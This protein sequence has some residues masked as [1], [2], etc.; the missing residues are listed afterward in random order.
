MTTHELLCRLEA[1]RSRGT[2][3][4]LARCPSHKD[5]SPS[6]SIGEGPDRILLHCFALCDNRD[7]VATVGFTMADLFFD[8]PIPRG[9]R[10]IARPVRIDYI[11]LAFRHELAALDRRLRAA[12]VL[13]VATNFSV[14]GLDHAQ[15]DRLMEAI[16]SAYSD[17]ER[18]EFLETVAD[19]LRV[20]AF[21]ERTA[22]HAA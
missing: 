7:I 1:V 10:P 4:W 3:K 19:D 12:N 20:K 13:K 8:A 22:H 16:A 5:Y 21:Q 2:G 6:L 11:A 15:L 18:A 9:R 14:E 17:R